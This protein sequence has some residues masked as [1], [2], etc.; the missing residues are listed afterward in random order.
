MAVDFTFVVSVTLLLMNTFT[1]GLRN[2]SKI[3]K[4]LRA[5]LRMPETP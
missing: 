1:K 4:R 5:E 3:V 2:D